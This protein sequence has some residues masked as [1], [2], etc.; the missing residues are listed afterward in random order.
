MIS[1]LCSIIITVFPRSTNLL[2]TSRSFSRSAKC[3][4]DV[5]SSRRYKAFPPLFESSVAS[6]TLC[7]SPPERVGAG[8]PSFI[9]DS[10]TSFKVCNLCD[11]PCMKEKKL[12]ES[13]TLIERTSAI[14]FPLKLTESASLLYWVPWQ[15]SHTIYTSG[16]NCISIF[17][18]PSPSQASHLPPLTLKENLPG[19]YP[20]SLASFV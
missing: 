10:P 16:I 9:Y 5:G 18:C 20:L 8:W 11:N 14:F 2:R 3:R 1:K 15:T 13:E 4:P 6:L 19:P 17:I 12:R 7:A